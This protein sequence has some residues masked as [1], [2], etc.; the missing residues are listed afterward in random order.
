MH[1]PDAF[2]LILHNLLL[3]LL[4]LLL[5]MVVVVTKPIRISYC[6]CK[7]VFSPTRQVDL[8]P[9]FLRLVPVEVL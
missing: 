3:L 6:K 2:F 7:S 4:L 8:S 9:L 1:F 5:V